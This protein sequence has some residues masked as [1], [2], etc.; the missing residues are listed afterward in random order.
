MISPSSTAR[1]PLRLCLALGAVAAMLLSA[2]S[3]VE[4]QVVQGVEQGAKAGNKAAGPVGG[5]LGGAIGGVVGVVTGVTGVLTGGNNA[6]KNA[7][8]PA[9]PATTD[10]QGTPKNGKQQAKASKDK[11]AKQ[12][13][14]LTQN[15]APQL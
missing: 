12:S 13:A 10:K 4:A 6:N 14:V 9:A 5:V 11:G 3:P 8:P 1:A 7:P 2:P 15:G